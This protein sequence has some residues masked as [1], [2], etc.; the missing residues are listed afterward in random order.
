MASACGDR[1]V[2]PTTDAE[3]AE[4]VPEEEAEAGPEGAVCGLADEADA[5]K[6]PVFT[7]RSW[8]NPP[9]IRRATSCCELP[10]A[11]RH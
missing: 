11:Q 8:M 10:A 5:G 2:P 4:D 9:G 6:E 1:G 7:G 3:A